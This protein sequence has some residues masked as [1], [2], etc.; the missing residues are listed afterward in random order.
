MML[1]CYVSIVAK[2]HTVVDGF[3]VS[4]VGLQGLGFGV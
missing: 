1:D 3:R 4:G 2:P